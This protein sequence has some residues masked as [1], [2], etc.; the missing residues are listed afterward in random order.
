MHLEKFLQHL[1]I[2]K[3]FSKHTI[4][5]YKTDLSQ[6]HAFL[7]LEYNISDISLVHHQLI[8]HWI[9]FLLES[10]ITPRS[11]KRKITTLKSYF[12]YLLQEDII[13]ENPT[14]KIISPKD[15]KKLPVFVERSK[16]ET[17]LSDIDFP[18]SFDGERDKLIID[19]F[20]MTGI[21]LSELLSLKIKDIDFRNSNI[22]VLGKRNKERVIPLSSNLLK[23]LDIFFM[24]YKINKYCFT[25]FSGKQLGSKQVY[26]IVNKYLSMVSGIEKRSP[27]VLRHTFATHMLNNGADI[28]AIKEILGHANLNATQVYTHNTVER[29]KKVYKQ[30]HPRA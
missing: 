7:L 21:R 6:F 8:R 9:S 26:N 30:A 19:V 13:D 11:V 4:N 20:Y 3:R 2:H 24:K 28:N 1:E 16:M 25:N 22:K 29:L 15:S 10:G 5:A 23:E 18:D 12:K 17:L 27:H 14:R